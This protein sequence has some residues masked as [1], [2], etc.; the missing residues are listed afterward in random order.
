MLSRIS[1]MGVFGILA[2]ILAFG[3]VTTDATAQFNADSM[4]VTVTG[5]TLADVIINRGDRL[6]AG[7]S[8]TTL[9]FTYTTDDLAEAN[10]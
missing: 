2:F 7:T 6:R 3:L 10:D 1:K 8:L 5:D 4:A 9:V